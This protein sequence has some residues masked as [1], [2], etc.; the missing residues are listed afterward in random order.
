MNHSWKSKKETSFLKSC[1]SRPALGFKYKMTKL[2]MLVQ[3]IFNNGDLEKFPSFSVEKEN[4]TPRG[5]SCC[6]TRACNLMNI[7]QEKYASIELP[8]NAIIKIHKYFTSLSS[9]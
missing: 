9:N 7:E 5:I 4:W 8:N 2:G 6:T 1:I 3:Y